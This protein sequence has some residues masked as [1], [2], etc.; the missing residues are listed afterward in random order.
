ML[1]ILILCACHITP[2]KIVITTSFIT[3][4]RMRGDL[5]YLGVKQ[6]CNRYVKIS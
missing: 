4:G 3:I 2:G 5:E 1:P 6:L